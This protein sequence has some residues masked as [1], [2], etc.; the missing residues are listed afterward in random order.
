MVYLGASPSLL[1]P[2]LA[3]RAGGLDPVPSPFLFFLVLIILLFYQFLS[4]YLFF[5]DRFM[6]EVLTRHFNEP[7]I[8]FSRFSILNIV[9]ISIGSISFL[10][11]VLGETFCQFCLVC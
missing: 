2:V 10:I 3:A 11:S 1:S 8:S 6:Y 4:V 9:F 7:F 5:Y